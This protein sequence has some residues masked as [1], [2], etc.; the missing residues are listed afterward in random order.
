MII[1]IRNETRWGYAKIVH[2]LRRLTHRIS[3]QSVKNTLVDAGIAP[4]PPT[5]NPDS[6]TEFFKRHAATL[7]QCDFAC[8]RK[9]TVKGMVD[10]Y[11]MVFIT[12]NR[13]RSGFRLAHQ[14][15]P[16]NGRHSKH[17]TV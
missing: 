3:R 2:A 9:W 16:D 4:D 14:T 15:Q 6:W 12:W 7:R 8:K 11:F 10:L 1:R 5:R 13:S 17:A